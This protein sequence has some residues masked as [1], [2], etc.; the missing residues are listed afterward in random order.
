MDQR[1]SLHLILT[2]PANKRKNDC[3]SLWVA[4]LGLKPR[5]VPQDALACFMWGHLGFLHW[6]EDFILCKH[7]LQTLR[8][9]ILQPSIVFEIVKKVL[10][11]RHAEFGSC[12]SVLT[13]KSWI[14]W[15]SITYLNNQASLPS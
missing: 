5:C 2:T 6:L 10:L 12:Y 9:K 1:V 3:N 15:K 8:P 4:P 11:S 13:R 14:N 7:L